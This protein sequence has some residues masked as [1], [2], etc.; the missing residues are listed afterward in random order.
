MP[1]EA[2]DQVGDSDK[3]E[4]EA[5]SCRPDAFF[6]DVEKRGWFFRVGPVYCLCIQTGL[7]LGLLGEFFFHRDAECVVR[8]GVKRLTA[9][10][11]LG[12]ERYIAYQESLREMVKSKDKY[13]CPL[14]WEA[15]VWVTRGR[16]TPSP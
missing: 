12:P 10:S 13:S 8:E 1:P 11:T 14:D 9:W 16:T 3:V 15:D 6:D 4:E 7:K 5:E 2:I